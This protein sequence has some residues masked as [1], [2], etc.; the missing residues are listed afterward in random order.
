MRPVAS[1]AGRFAARDLGAEAPYSMLKLP[2][3]STAEP[4]IT[5]A[6]GCESERERG[7]QDGCGIADRHGVFPRLRLVST[8]SLGIATCHFKSAAGSSRKRIRRARKGT[9]L[10]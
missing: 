6:A 2:L 1:A 10:S 4:N 9:R 7:D 8:R 3:M 5:S